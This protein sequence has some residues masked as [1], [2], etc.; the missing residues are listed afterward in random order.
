MCTRNTKKGT[1]F[2]VAPPSTRMQYKFLR[3]QLPQMGLYGTGQA[4]F[5]ALLQG[6]ASEGLTAASKNAGAGQI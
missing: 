4:R 5:F 6:F 1:R 3:L 2:H